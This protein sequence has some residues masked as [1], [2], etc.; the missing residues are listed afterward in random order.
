MRYL[1]RVKFNFKW[2]FTI[3]HGI[4]RDYKRLCAIYF[5]AEK[6]FSLKMNFT[7]LLFES[8]AHI[9]THW[10]LKYANRDYPFIITGKVR[11]NLWFESLEKKT[12]LGGRNQIL[13]SQI[14]LNLF[15]SISWLSPFQLGAQALRS[16]R[17]HVV[18][19]RI[20]H[21]PPNEGSLWPYS[22][23]SPPCHFGL[24]AEEEREGKV[25]RGGESGREKKERV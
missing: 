11:L 21:C 2:P 18:E 19:E 6:D 8:R 13:R 5:T 4:L 24:G 23:H 17:R 1:V 15:S 20:P 25:R 3:A 7:A 12:G 22:W 16:W 9:N 10:G 14:R